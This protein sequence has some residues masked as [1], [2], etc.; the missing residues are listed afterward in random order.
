MSCW[1]QRGRI[2]GMLTITGASLI[3][4]ACGSAAPQVVPSP[5]EDGVLEF[6]SGRDSTDLQNNE[7][8]RLIPES[9]YQSTETQVPFRFTLPES[10]RLWQGVWEDEWSA[11]IVFSIE[12]VV[13]DP[14]ALV[15]SVAEEGSTPEGVADAMRSSTPEFAWEQS[16]GLF[17][18]RDAIVLEAT[19]NRDSLEEQLGPGVADLIFLST[20]DASNFGVSVA[21]DRSYRSQIFEEQGR[22]VIVTIDF[23]TGIEAE[24]T[25][26]VAPVLASLEIRG[27][28]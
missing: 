15:L 27:A 7:A 10:D 12:G 24:V 3:A 21:D 28:S 18:G 25:A 4:A 11:A 26:E 23:A 20:G 9:T 2:L 22:V 17:E 19:T 1:N 13:N 16:S 14:P 8:A 6:A 5:L